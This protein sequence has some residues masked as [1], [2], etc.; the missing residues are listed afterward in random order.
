MV[1]PMATVQHLMQNRPEVE[2]G[3]VSRS[4]L[5]DV[6]LPVLPG[7]AAV[8]DNVLRHAVAALDR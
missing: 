6:D 7:T 8:A 3:L 2:L 5:V 1:M 4:V